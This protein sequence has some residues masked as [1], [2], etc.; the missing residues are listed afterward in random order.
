MALEELNGS[1]VAFRL[2]ERLERPEV[3]ASTCLGVF[4][5]RVQPVASRL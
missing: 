3:S 2:S 1:F 4:L 5:A